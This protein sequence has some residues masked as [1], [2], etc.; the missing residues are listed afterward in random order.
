MKEENDSKFVTI[1]RGIFFFIFCCFLIQGL[2]V[3]QEIHTEESSL[4][5]V[6]K[7]S[8]YFETLGNGAYYSINY[9]RILPIKDKVALFG[10]IGGTI[11]SEANTHDSLLLG[12]IVEPGLLVGGLKNFFET[13]VGYTYFS[14]N[15]DHLFVI[16][17]G[18]RYHGPKGLVF[19]ATPMYIFNTNNGDVF[20]NSLWIGISIG[21]A[22]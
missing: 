5:N 16:T 3:A 4:K 11:F 2:L 8:F 7:N 22:F 18:Y 17:A 19:R 6:R 15:T 1:L 12:L 21:Y 20:G 14:N 10:R 13:G 9:D